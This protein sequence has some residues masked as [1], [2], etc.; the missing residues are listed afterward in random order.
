M[1]KPPPTTLPTERKLLE[2]LGERIRLARLRRK[3]SMVLVAERA[4][5]SRITLHRIEKGDPAVTFGNYLRVLMVLGLERDVDILA[6]DDELGRRL[7]D[8]ELPKPRSSKA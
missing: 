2:R 8:L 6:R 4:G 5:M 3:F 1:P 7:Q